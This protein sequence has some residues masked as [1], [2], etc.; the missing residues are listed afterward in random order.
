MQHTIKVPSDLSEITVGQYQDYLIKTKHLVGDDIAAM[1]VSVFCNIDLHAVN[2]MTASDI[3][4]IAEG[5]NYLFSVDHELI[6]RVTLEGTDLGFV[7]SL[8]KMSFGEYID[9]DESVT[10]WANMHT[11]LAVLYRPVTMT[12]G[13]RYSIA[14]YVGADQ[15]EEGSEMSYQDCMKNLPMSVALGATVFFYA[16]G[17]ESLEI[18]INY[19]VK[20]LEVVMSTA[21][22]HNSHSNGGGITA[23]IKSLKE[24]LQDLTEQAESPYMKPLVI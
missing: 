16:L 7:P 19:L 5:I 13:E 24:M 15:I 9:L 6:T 17:K 3:I 4:S 23:Y 22:Q 12:H 2:Y 18:T 8:D 1:T 10:D 14:E 21:V 11:A 20:E